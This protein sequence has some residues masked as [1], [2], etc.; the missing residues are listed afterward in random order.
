M[1]NV[2]VAVLL[3]CAIKSVAQNNEGEVQ[4]T[5]KMNMWSM[6][7]ERMTEEEDAERLEMIKSF[8]PE[9]REVPKVLYFTAEESLFMNGEKE[10]EDVTEIHG[11]GM[12]MRMMGM[13]EPDERFYTDITNGIKIEQKD[14]MGKLF[15]IEDSVETYEWKLTAETKTIEGYTCMKATTTRDSM[16]YEVWFTMQIPVSTGP[17]GIGGLPGLV[18]EGSTD[19]GNFMMVADSISLREITEEELEKPSKGKNV[20]Q[21]EYEEI[22]EEKMLEMQEQYGGRGDGMHITVRD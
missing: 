10:E 7:E 18:L 22:Q 11:D 12:H 9:W 8:M 5:F 20:T 6:M 16:E 21:E 1:K 15:L 3:F 14:L 19:N 13:E 17:M 4:Y 2:V